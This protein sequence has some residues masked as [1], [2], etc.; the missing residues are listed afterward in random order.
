MTPQQ[1]RQMLDAMKGEERM[2]PVQIEKRNGR[3][4][5]DW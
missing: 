5:K 4:I 1:A 3:I 2:M